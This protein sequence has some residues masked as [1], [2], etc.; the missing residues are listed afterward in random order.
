MTPGPSSSAPDKFNRFAVCF[1]DVLG[2]ESRFTA[3]GLGGMLEKY[4]QLIDIVGRHN[5]RMALLFDRVNFSETAYWAA[6]GDISISNR[7]Y[8]A[9]ASDSILLF[10][11]A[12]FPENRYPAALSLTAEERIARS[13]DPASGWMYQ[14]VPCDGFLDLCCEVLCHSV[15]I[16]LPLRGALVMGEAVLHLDRRIFL[17][18]PLIEA[19]R[20]EHQQCFIGASLASSFVDQLV[21]AR[22]QLAF[23]DHFKSSPPSNFAGTILDW[24]RHWRNTRS[25]DLASAVGALDGDPKFS[26]Y[27]E[28]TLKTIVAS[29]SVAGLH[30]SSADI[31]TRSV[32]PQFNGDQV[33][34]A[35]R[36]FRAEPR[37]PDEVDPMKE[38]GSPDL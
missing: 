38:S 21:P 33:V 6:G 35:A 13:K 28:T 25:D 1:L 2:F 15:E 10:A 12:D 18:G 19:A 11:H 8:G 29:S 3:L 37:E 17:G 31:D 14:P 32:Y 7:L 9:Y 30:T 26:A 20:M 24:P 22:Y 23:A 16:G 5:D 36:P 34:A 27:Y 4:T